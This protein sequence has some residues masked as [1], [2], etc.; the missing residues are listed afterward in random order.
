MLKRGMLYSKS[1]I[2]TAG[3]VEGQTSKYIHVHPLIGT[4][5]L[6]T[7][8]GHAQKGA[9]G[10]IVAVIPATVE[11]GSPRLEIVLSSYNLHAP[12]VRITTE[13][14]DVVELQ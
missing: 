4:E 6:I 8:N 12:F 3:P 5:V 10:R 13:Y 7:R 11:H 14:T 1:T 9:T 2:S